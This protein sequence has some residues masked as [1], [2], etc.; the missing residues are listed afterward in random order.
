[1]KFLLYSLLLHGCS[2][3]SA[4]NRFFRDLEFS[5]SPLSHSC[6]R[7]KMKEIQDTKGTES[8]R[9]AFLLGNGLVTK[10]R[11]LEKNDVREFNNLFITHYSHS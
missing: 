6:F 7:G 3:H 1:M 9:K 2:A 8:Y 10:I 4:G 11:N 5:F